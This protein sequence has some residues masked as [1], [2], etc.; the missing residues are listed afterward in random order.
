M[1]EKNPIF[2]LLHGHV[3]RVCCPANQLLE[4]TKKK[5]HIPLRTSWISQTD[6]LVMFDNHTILLFWLWNKQF[7][8]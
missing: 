7:V 3:F 2:R 5:A 4:L 1:T 8:K 6:V